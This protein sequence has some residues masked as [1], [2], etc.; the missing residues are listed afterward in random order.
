MSN[1][2]STTA[3]VIRTYRSGN[4]SISVD[5]A[6]LQKI[7]NSEYSALK[8]LSSELDGY[9]RRITDIAGVM[10]NE[11]SYQLGNWNGSWASAYYGHMSGNRQSSVDKIVEGVADIHDAFWSFFDEDKLYNLETQDDKD[12]IYRK[13]RDYAE[14][15]ADKKVC[16]DKMLADYE[17][18]ISISDS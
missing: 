1:S 6:K 11:A 5:L 14:E 18:G 7:S 2:G 4:T 9:Q 17:A 12:T 13:I 8:S 15:I 16:I 10:A 3:S